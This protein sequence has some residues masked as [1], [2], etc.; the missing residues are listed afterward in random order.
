MCCSVVYIYVA[1]RSIC[2][3]KEAIQ[4]NRIQIW[5]RNTIRQ[6][7][8][9][10]VKSLGRGGPP[11]RSSTPYP[12]LLPARSVSHFLDEANLKN[13]IHGHPQISNLSSSILSHPQESME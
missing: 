3:I 4:R 12:R 6:D 9:E 2:N 11:S 8:V 10:V 5:E 1:L 7:I 13:P